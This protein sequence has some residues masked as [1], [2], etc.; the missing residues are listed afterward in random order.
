[1]KGADDY[2]IKPLTAEVLVQKLEM[3][4]TWRGRPVLAA[5]TEGAA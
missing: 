2:V 5:S 4:D 3:L 1:M